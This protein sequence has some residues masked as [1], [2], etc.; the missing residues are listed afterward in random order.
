MSEVSVGL[1]TGMMFGI[2]F[3]DLDED[4]TFALVIDL[5]IIRLMFIRWKEAE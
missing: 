1:I 5:V 2:E 4:M 3:P